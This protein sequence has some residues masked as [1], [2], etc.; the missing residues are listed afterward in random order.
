MTS[1]LNHRLCASRGGGGQRGSVSVM[2]PVLIASV[3]AVL[4]LAFDGGTAITAHQRAIG[5]AEQA[6]RAGAQQVSIASVRSATGPY[7]LVPDVARRAT[8]AYLRRIGVSGGRVQVG[9]DATGD[10]VEVTVPWTHPAVFARLL[11]F[12]QFIGTGTARARL[13]HGVVVEEAC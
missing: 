3:L 12:H 9:H 13:C 11:G 5:I 6:A 10:F 1:S 4:G 8:R 7:R 2:A